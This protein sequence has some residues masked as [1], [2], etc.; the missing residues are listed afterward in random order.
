LF[1]SKSKRLV[2]I[3]ALKFVCEHMPWFVGPGCVVTVSCAQRGRARSCHARVWPPPRGGQGCPR[4]GCGWLRPAGRYSSPIASRCCCSA[5]LLPHLL[6][7]PAA[8]R[9]C[10]T[11]V[12]LLGLRLRCAAAP[13]HAC[14]GL[15]RPLRR[16]HLD[17]ASACAS[18]RCRGHRLAI[19]GAARVRS[20]WSH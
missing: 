19:Y 17:V 8:S 2:V 20:L 18:P 4:P 3:D 12:A 7:Y 10:P 11:I 15:A 9:R 14:V 16:C 13:N 1:G 5:L 6:P